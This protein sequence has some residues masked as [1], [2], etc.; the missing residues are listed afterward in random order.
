MLRK[1][2]GRETVCLACLKPG[3]LLQHHINQI[4][5]WMPIILALALRR[6]RQK[7]LECMAFFFLYMVSSRPAW[8]TY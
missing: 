7:I 2:L 1:Q 5:W 4:G 6:W 8:D 3:F